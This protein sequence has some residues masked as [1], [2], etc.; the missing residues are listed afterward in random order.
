MLE[1]IAETDALWV[2]NKPSGVSL[3]RDRAGHANLWDI[4]KASHPKPYLV[5]RLD[6]GTS[7]VL[8]IAK[9]QPTQTR[10]TQLFATRT[11][12]K[13]YVARVL[14]KLP[15]GATMTIELPLCKGRKSKYRVAGERSAIELQGNR[16]SVAQSREGVDAITHA[17]ALRTEDGTSIV[18]L[19]PVTGRTHQLR[20]H[21]S[22]IGH[23]IIGDELYGRPAD[24]QQRAA[25]LML[26]CHKLVVP[27]FGTF[28]ADAFGHDSICS[29]GAN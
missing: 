2:L 24:P 14:G 1:I 4:F 9:N 19:H 7:G 22:W 11:I 20:V 10:L 12:S 25:R 3:L 13:Y 18:A 16:F 6:K 8:L 27:G 23:P 21:L 17:R 15:I 28:N 26:H 5:H 29:P